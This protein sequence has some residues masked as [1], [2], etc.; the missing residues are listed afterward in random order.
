MDADTSVYEAEN[1]VVYQRLPDR[2]RQGHSQRRLPQDY[3]GRSAG[4]ARRPIE[5]VS[6]HPS[7]TFLR[8]AEGRQQH[9]FRPSVDLPPAFWG[10][11][12][13]AW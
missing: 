11:T 13:G 5:C 10:G 2:G 4:A 1:T 12:V 9:Q 6:K 3:L 7:C 8:C